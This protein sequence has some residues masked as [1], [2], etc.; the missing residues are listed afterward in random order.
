MGT[1]RAREFGERNSVP[2]EILVRVRTTHAV[3][4]ADLADSAAAV[5]RRFVLTLESDQISAITWSAVN[6]ASPQFA[7]LH[8]LGSGR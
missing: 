5:E 6:S 7:V 3:G 8:E 1:A 4:Q 2:G